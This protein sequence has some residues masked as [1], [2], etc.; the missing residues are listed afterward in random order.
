MSSNSVSLG[1][2]N[3]KLLCTCLVSGWA[4]PMRPW[5]AASV[6]S[7][8]GWWPMISAS[9]LRCFLCRD[10]AW[11]RF[12]PS[13]SDAARGRCS[14]IHCCCA[15]SSNTNLWNRNDSSSAARRLWAGSR[16]ALNLQSF[17]IRVCIKNTVTPST[18]LL[19]FLNTFHMFNTLPR[20]LKHTAPDW[21]YPNCWKWPHCMSEFFF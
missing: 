7:I 3:W 6:R 18:Q 12:C 4:S 8:I 21:S 1:H 17:S 2:V 19:T 15:S 9:S 13:F 20:G 16:S 10:C 11:C 14:L 5:P